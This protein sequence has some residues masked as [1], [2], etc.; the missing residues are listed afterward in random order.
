MP[1]WVTNGEKEVK[2]F[3]L[4]DGSANRHVISKDICRSLKLNGKAVN[5]QITTLDKTVE[6]EREVADVAV[7][8]TNGYR[9]TLNNAI[10]GEIIA[11]KDDRPPCVEGMEHLTDVEFPTFPNGGEEDCVIG[12]VIG[13]EHARIWMG[14]EKHIG[15]EGLPMGLSTALGSGL[16][17]PKNN[18]DSCYFVCNFASFHSIDSDLTKSVIVAKALGGQRYPCPA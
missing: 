15:A 2:T 18:T 3:A 17:G 9:L 1:L 8:G 11:S 16:I 14:G 4:L 10:F 6:G 13:A 12:V 5:M 7:K